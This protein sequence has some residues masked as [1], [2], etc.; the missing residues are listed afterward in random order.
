MW[1]DSHVVAWPSWDSSA[2]TRGLTQQGPKQHEGSVLFPHPRARHWHR[3]AEQA[4][5]TGVDSPAWQRSPHRPP[6][7]LPAHGAAPSTPW[8]PR[9]S[10][11]MT[12]PGGC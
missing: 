9:A 11:A 2:S 1:G 3:E 5:S 6:H 4:L 8:S 10:V 12:G 7:L